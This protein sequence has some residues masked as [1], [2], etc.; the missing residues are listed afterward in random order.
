MEMPKKSEFKLDVVS[1]RL[2]KD[3]PIYSQNPV[4]SPQKAVDLLGELLCE[5][6]R[7]VVCV[8]NLKSNMVPI[9]VHFAS[10]GALN[11]AMAH[12]RE[13]MKASILSNAAFMLLLHC[14]PS[15]NLLPSKEDTMMTD[16]MNKVCEMMGIP[17]VDHIIVGG[18]NHEFFSF[19]E[20]KMIENP[21]IMLSTDYR[22]LDF[23]S[24]LVAEKGKAR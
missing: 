22:T 3:A 24:P 21:R 1:V 16:R 13:I 19:K 12:P 7:E 2:V 5:L 17:L 9:N 15:G 20:K 18:D 8:L 10:M 6:D 14:H 11:Q 23:G 4:D